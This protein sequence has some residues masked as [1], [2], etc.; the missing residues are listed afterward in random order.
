MRSKEDGFLDRHGGQEAVVLVDKGGDLGDVR[1]G[2][3]LLAVQDDLARGLLQVPAKNV[4]ESRLRACKCVVM[5][6]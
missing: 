2:A 1:W 3:G 4:Q 6:Q 5:C